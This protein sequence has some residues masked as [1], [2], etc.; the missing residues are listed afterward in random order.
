MRNSTGWGFYQQGSDQQ[1]EIEELGSY[2]SLVIGCSVHYPAWGKNMYECLH[3][4]VFPKY[5]V[6]GKN[7]KVL[8][9]KHNEMVRIIQ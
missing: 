5:L 1:I 2:L 6:K 8:Q 9:G 4:V 3:G 7:S